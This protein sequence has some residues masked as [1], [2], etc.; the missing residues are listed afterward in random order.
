MASQFREDR[1]MRWIMPTTESLYWT[2]A[3]CGQ[4]AVMKSDVATSIGSISGTLLYSSLDRKVHTGRLLRVGA[5][6]G[7]GVG[8]ES[9][10]GLGLGLGLKTGACGLN[11][12]SAELE[13]VLEE[14]LLEWLVASE[15]KTSFELVAELFE[16]V[17]LDDRS[18]DSL[19]VDH[20]EPLW[21]C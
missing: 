21:E 7:T 19:S 12:V 4:S 17:G 15:D 5:D 10:T 9:E 13:E 8:S 2:C 6:V 1:K 18:A 20:C 14:I 16:C 11:G 3:C